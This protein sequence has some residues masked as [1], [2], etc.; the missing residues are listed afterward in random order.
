MHLIYFTWLTGT[1]RS[2][3]FVVMHIWV[4]T[5]YTSVFNIC[6]EALTETK[7]WMYMSIKFLSKPI[8][9]FFNLTKQNATISVKDNEYENAVS[10]RAAIF[11]SQGINLVSWNI[12][13]AQYKRDITSLLTHWSYISF[14]LNYRYH[15]E[16]IHWPGMIGLELS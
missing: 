11:L 16:D 4:T 13:M 1:R 12:S 14:A 3:S 2:I 9:A 7:Q 15:D 8:L 10:K 5:W 6:I